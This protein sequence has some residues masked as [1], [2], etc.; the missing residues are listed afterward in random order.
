MKVTFD[1]E[2]IK[3]ISLFQNL[4][5]AHVKDIQD[6]PDILY[7]VVAEGEYG[8]AVGKDGQTIKKAEGVFKKPIKVFEYTPDAE[9]FVR[10]MIPE[11]QQISV[12]EKTIRVRIPAQARAHV[13]GKGGSRVKIMGAFLQRLHDIESFKVQ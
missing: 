9:Q 4:T 7:I 12:V 11:A 5:G 2:T 8:L 3:T 10:N 6:S 1:T 13:L